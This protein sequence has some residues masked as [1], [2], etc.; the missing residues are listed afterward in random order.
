MSS[1]LEQPFAP[2]PLRTLSTPTLAL[3]QEATNR[4]AKTGMEYIASTY[5]GSGTIASFGGLDATHLY[6][7]GSYAFG[8]AALVATGNHDTDT[9]TYTDGQLK[10]TAV[11]LISSFANLHAANGGT[12]GGVVTTGDPIRE[13][14]GLLTT[15]KWQGAWWVAHIG[16]AAKLIWEELNSSQQ[17]AV[18]DMVQLEANRFLNYSVPYARNRSGIEVGFPQDT[19][20]EENGWNGWL[21]ILAAGWW[22][23]HQNA[24][25]WLSKGLELTYSVGATVL[26]PTSK[27]VHNGMTGWGLRAGSN[28]E[29]IGAVPNH[30]QTIHPQYMAGSIAQACLNGITCAWLFGKFPAVSQTLGL[31]LIYRGFMDVS[32]T[33]VLSPGTIYDTA[34]QTYA[35]N[36]PNGMDEFVTNEAVYR[37]FVQIFMNADVQA[38][39]C[40]CDDLGSIPAATWAYIHAQR[41]L[42]LQDDDLA[43]WTTSWDFN[44]GAWSLFSDWVI[45]TFEVT[46]TN[47]SAG[48]IL[49]GALSS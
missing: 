41:Q 36:Y 26:F 25:Q 16:A 15:Q 29:T 48:Q 28:I 31:R 13:T 9:T 19:K 3:V 44:T 22:P 18:T 6:R 35:I 12:W 37:Q 23:E 46:V 27:R 32:Y 7:I 21:L 24:L 42:D 5:P 10:T 8:F 43:L 14:P 11:R 34:G 2:L 39:V 47:E 4:A 1:P 20:S 33:N 30:N 38:H 45:R 17:E 49:S 40:G